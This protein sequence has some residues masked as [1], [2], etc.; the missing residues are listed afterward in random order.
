MRKFLL[1]LLLAIIAV[2]AVWVFAGKEISVVADQTKTRKIESMP[3]QSVSYEGSGE[4]GTLVL[5]N[6]RFTLNSINPSVVIG[7]SFGSVNIQS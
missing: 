4:G 2:T 5:N 3:L 1:I 7:G 6:E